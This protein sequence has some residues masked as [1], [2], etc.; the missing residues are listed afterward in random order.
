MMNAGL[1]PCYSSKD[2][3]ILAY[4]RGLVHFYESGDYTQYA[5][6]FLN[7]LLQRLAEI[8]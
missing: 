5:D 1:I 8:E 4:R 6:Y 7:R 2:S 3:D